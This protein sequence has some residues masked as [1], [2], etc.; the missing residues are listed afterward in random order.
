MLIVKRQ[1]KIEMSI[2]DVAGQTL[3]VARSIAPRSQVLRETPQRIKL[4]NFPP[5]QR[6]ISV[7]LKQTARLIRADL[8]KAYRLT[9]F[10]VR[11]QQMSS[12]TSVINVRWS[13][14]GPEEAEVSALLERYRGAASDGHEGMDEVVTLIEG[15]WYHFEVTYI[16]CQRETMVIDG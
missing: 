10:M 7:T 1:A 3:T 8:R 11:I 12:G 4:V 14:D 6:Y 9:K 15:R 5:D 13:S 2:T 16:S